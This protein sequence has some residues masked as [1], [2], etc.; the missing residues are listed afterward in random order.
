MEA[1]VSSQQPPVQCHRLAI[2]QTREYATSPSAHC[3]WVCPFFVEP[4]TLACQRLFAFRT[5][6]HVHPPT[7]IY[8]HI[9]DVL[10]LV[11]TIL[12]PFLAS[13][14]FEF[15]PVFAVV[16]FITNSSPFPCETLCDTADARSICVT[17]ELSSSSERQFAATV[18]W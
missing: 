3:V 16:I 5:S 11:P 15:P 10:P 18:Q 14:Q 13:V 4:V 2:L 12:Y 17:T 6:K 8:S 9:A 7:H 1:S